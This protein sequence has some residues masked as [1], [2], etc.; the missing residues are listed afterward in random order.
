MIYRLRNYYRLF[1]WGLFGVLALVTVGTATPITT[2]PVP[3][4]YAV[5]DDNRPML[6]DGTPVGTTYRWQDVYT[7][8]ATDGLNADND[9]CVYDP[10]PAGDPRAVEPDN[11]PVARRYLP[12]GTDVRVVSGW[13]ATPPPGDQPDP[14]EVTPDTDDATEVNEDDPGWDCRT[15][16]N[17]VCGPG[18]TYAAG[19]YVRRG[20]DARTMIRPWD[21]AMAADPHYR[22]DGCGKRTARDRAMDDR[23]N[24]TTG[25][26][27]A[28]NTTGG[29]TCW[30][31]D[32][33][34]PTSAT[35]TAYTP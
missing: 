20:V 19:C 7:C 27:C 9:P 13:S 28:D 32:Q 11:D 25:Q 5:S 18:A 8:A 15:M 10:D 21:A 6:P 3:V 24:G 2:S 33:P 14:G 26:L 23:L 16:G 22:P 31:V 35:G 4:V 17:G 12:D 34:R 29:M 30:Y 1:R